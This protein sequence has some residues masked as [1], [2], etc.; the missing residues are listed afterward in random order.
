MALGTIEE[1]TSENAN[2]YPEKNSNHDTTSNKLRQSNN[3]GSDSGCMARVDFLA[4]SSNNDPGE[5]RY[6]TGM[7]S[8]H[9]ATSE[10]MRKTSEEMFDELRVEI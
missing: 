2:S 7:R 10:E 5:Y 4:K 1:A 6:L 3:L 9:S 8:M